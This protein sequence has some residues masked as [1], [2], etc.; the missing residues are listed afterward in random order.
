M[1]LAGGIEEAIMDRDRFDDLTK[2]LALEHPTRRRVLTGLAGAVMGGPGLRGASAA[3]GG[4]SAAAKW[5]HA[6]FSGA[7]AGQC[8]SQAAQGTG[9]YYGCAG[10]GGT[11]CATC[12]TCSSSGTCV[13]AHDLTPCAFVDIY[14]YNSTGQCVSGACVCKPPGSYCD[15]NDFASVAGCCGGCSCDPPICS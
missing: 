11:P 2:R 1:P 7:A 8:T 12:Q 15:C 5:C 6:T 13:Q 3:A 10:P 9:P 14:G 4:N